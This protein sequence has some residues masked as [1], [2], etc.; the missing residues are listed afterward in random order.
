MRKLF[1]IVPIMKK[2][3][4][5]VIA[6]V[7]L[8]PLTAHSE[9]KAGSVEV[10]PFVGYNFFEKRQN[11]DNNPVFGGRIGYNFTN[12]LGIEA[13]GEYIR[14]GVDDRSKAFT[15]EG[16][17][18][19]PINNVDIIMYHLDLIYHFMPEARFNPF[20]VAGYG[21]AHYSPK[22]NNR[23]MAIVDF[24]VGAKYWLTDNIAL[25]ADV[26]DKMVFDET[27]H[28]IEA[29]AGVVFAFGGTSKTTPAKAEKPL[30][31]DNDGVVD[32]LDKC[33]G[34]PAGVAVDQDGC[35]LDSDGDGVPD[36]LD[37]CPGTPVGVS[38]DKDGCPLDSDKDGV[39]DYLDKCPGTPAGV[40]VDKDGCPLDSDKDGVPDY[41][42]KCPGT[43]AGVAVDQDGCPRVVEKV[44]II[45]SAPKPEEKVLVAAYEK[46]AEKV[47]VLAFEDIHFDFD[48]STLKPE[49]KLIL[50]R[51][52]QLLKENPKAKIRVAGYTSASGTAEYNQKLSE[53]R[54]NVVKEYLVNEGIISKDR[55]STVGYGETRPET[56]ESAP[57]DIYSAAAQSNMRV[58]FEII[59]E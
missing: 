24:G 48:E 34:T 59:L 45:L 57:K 15:R 42:D 27:I 11:L 47:V 17:F 38:V 41:L 22:I 52:I 33:P 46:K 35:P 2:M 31:S 21:G 7:F 18:T 6:S 4:P 58:L 23:D 55:L 49:A 5:V 3:A 54:A 40:A 28:N 9:I 26:R 56:Y 29:S 50:K 13:T 20:I 14:S 8:L 51:D 37:K 16:Q 12:Y 10:S 25:R 36:Y 1:S 53:R 43:P 32:P 44:L 19:T 39:P 30:D